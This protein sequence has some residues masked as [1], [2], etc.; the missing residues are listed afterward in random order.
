MKLVCWDNLRPVRIEM[1]G[2]AARASM[3]RGRK[4]RGAVG[5]RE[6]MNGAARPDIKMISDWGLTSGT[7]DKGQRCM[8]KYEMGRC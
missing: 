4:G 2:S 1:R 3:R 8:C 7:A 6:R 5:Q